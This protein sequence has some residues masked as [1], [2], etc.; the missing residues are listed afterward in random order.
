[1]WYYA[2]FEEATGRIVRTG[3]VGQFSDLHLQDNGEEGVSVVETEGDPTGAVMIESTHWVVPNPDYEEPGEGEEPLPTHLAVP[4]PVL[5][6][7]T[8]VEIVA[9]GA[10]EAILP[11]LPDPCEAVVDGEPVTV[12]GGQLVLTAD[13]PAVYDVE[14]LPWPQMPHTVRITAS[15]P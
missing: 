5:G 12:T 4:R 8:E 9:D 13:V 11:G 15:A 6:L 7:P 10:D 3:S 2:V 14:L 1:M